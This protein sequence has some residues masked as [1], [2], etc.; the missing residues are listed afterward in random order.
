MFCIVGEDPDRILGAH[1][2]TC[3]TWY[4][5]LQATSPVPGGFAST[6]LQYLSSTQ[7]PSEG[8]MC[9]CVCMHLCSVCVHVCV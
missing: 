4:G 3:E 7:V 6:D 8:F 1:T 9:V 5:F 2:L